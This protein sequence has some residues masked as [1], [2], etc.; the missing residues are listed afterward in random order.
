MRCL[1]R[2]VS[3]IAL[4]GFWNCDDE[5]PQIDVESAI[6]V[7][8]GKV[9]QWPIAEYVTVTGTAR[10]QREGTLHCLQAGSYQ[11]QDNPRTGEPFAMGD[12]VFENELIVELDN[13]ELV[14]QAGMDSKKL[15][16]TSAEREYE[17]QQALFAKGGLPLRELTEAELEQLRSATATAE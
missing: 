15:A 6:P 11:L 3:V 8:V 14:N 16:F 17:K 10:A 12:E 2:S 7:R 1:H 4:A 5:G 9:A 13:P